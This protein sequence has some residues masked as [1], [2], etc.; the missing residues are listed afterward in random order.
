MGNA[1]QHCKA[2]LYIHFSDGCHGDNFGFEHPQKN[3]EIIW[4]GQEIKGIRKE[5]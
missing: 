1:E 5:F 2:D 3:I 4:D